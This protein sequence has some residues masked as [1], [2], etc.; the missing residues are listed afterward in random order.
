MINNWLD[1]TEQNPSSYT[2]R[3]IDVTEKVTPDDDIKEY[4]GGEILSSY[5]N[6]G[7]LKVQYEH[8]PEQNLREYIKNY[9]I[10]T[11]SNQISKNVRQ[12]DFGEILTSLIVSYFEGLEVPLKKLRWKFNSERAVFCTDLIAHNSGKTISDI[13]YYE[14]KSRLNITRETVLGQSNYVTVIAH[15]SLLKDEQIPSEGIADF[16][17]RYF[18]EM[19]DFDSSHKYMDIVKNPQNYGRNFELFFIIEQSKFISNIFTDLNNLPPKL[20]PLRVTVVLISG[21]GRLIIETQNLAI[22]QAVNFVYDK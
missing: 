20:N 18:F 22:E 2:F 16:L 12:G 8:E 11:S 19:G 6:L 9:A 21:L 10:P 3:I 5:R 15:N 13:Y 1:Y 14:V 7:F 17:G 4:L